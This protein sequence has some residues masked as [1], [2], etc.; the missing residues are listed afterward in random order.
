MRT[1][2]TGLFFAAMA[3]MG[4]WPKFAP[5]EERVAL[6]MERYGDIRVGMSVDDA[7]KALLKTGPAE[8]PASTMDDCDYYQPRPGLAFMTDRRAIVRIEVSED[9]AVTPSG[10]RIGDPLSKV[11]AI[12]GNTVTDEPQFYD[13]PEARTLTALSSDRK[14]AM[15]FEIYDDRVREIY[16]GYEADI[17]FVEGCL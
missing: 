6:T 13:G 7:Y 5:A 1:L 2:R 14:T 15:R 3:A 16:A 17:H 9:I 11:K 10:I 12:F 8:K 4:L